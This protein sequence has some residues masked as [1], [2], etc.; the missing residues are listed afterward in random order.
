MSSDKASF[1]SPTCD[2]LTFLTL[3]ISEGS[4]SKC[5]TALAL[6]ANLSG[7]AATLSSNLEPNAITKSQSSTA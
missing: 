3:L 1:N 4:I 2:Q 7:S 6:G 5:A